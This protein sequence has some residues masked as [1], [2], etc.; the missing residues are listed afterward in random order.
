MAFVR[1]SHRVI[2]A[3]GI[4][5]AV[6]ISLA[7]HS[8]TLLAQHS[9]GTLNCDCCGATMCCDDSFYCEADSGC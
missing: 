5:V 6:A 9:H 8:A 1:A 4:A 3:L 7:A 2:Q